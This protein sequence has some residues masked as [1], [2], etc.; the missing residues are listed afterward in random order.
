MKKIALVG[1]GY[2]GP[3]LLRNILDNPEASLVV[4]CDKDPEKLKIINRRYPTVRTTTEYRQVLQDKTVDAVVLATPIFTHFKLARQAILSGKDVLVEKPLAMNYLEAKE[5]TALAAKRRRILMV[6][7]PFLFS[8]AVHKIKK[9]LDSGEI[10]EILYL[11]CVRVNLG[12][13]QKDSNVIFDLAIHDFSIIQ[14]LLNAKPKSLVCEAS[15]HF[16]HQYDLAYILMEYADGVTAHVQVS[17]LSPAKMR[18]MIIVG[19]KKMIVYDDIEPTEK[20]RVYDRGVK[21]SRSTRE[22]EEMKVGYRS[23]DVWIP[24]V[25]TIEPLAVMIAEFIKALTSRKTTVSGGH[26]SAEIVN[27]LES[28]TKSAQSGRKIIFNHANRQKR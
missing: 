10:G 26:W 27:F 14:F 20:V 6:D 13:F 3:F 11:D 12:L 24:K 9:I 23:G 15:T 5:L 17:W 25:E 1:Y 16:G 2:W 4:V 8:D 19:T 22:I 7:H 28:S 18:R 21:I